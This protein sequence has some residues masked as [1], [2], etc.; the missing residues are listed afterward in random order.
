MNKLIRRIAGMK[1][2]GGDQIAR[3]SPRLPAVAP[4][5]EGRTQ[6][7]S[8]QHAA[9]AIASIPAVALSIITQSLVARAAATQV[10]LLR[11]DQIGLKKFKFLF[12]TLQAFSS[13]ATLRAN[14]I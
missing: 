2:R 9:S 11:C 3:R 7:Q 13:L 14:Y 10:L 12:S 6:T 8:P 1:K 4:A 5:K